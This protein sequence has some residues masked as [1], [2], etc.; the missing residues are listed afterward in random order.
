MKRAA[1]LVV[2]AALLAGCD[3]NFHVD[4]G[5]Q[6]VKSTWERPGDGELRVVVT[7]NNGSVYAGHE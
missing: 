6:G 1:A 2:L 5:S 4:C 7:C 3:N